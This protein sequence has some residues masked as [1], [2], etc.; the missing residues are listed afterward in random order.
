M[1]SSIE[2]LLHALVREISSGRHFVAVGWLPRWI[3]RRS[4]DAGT[5]EDEDPRWAD[6][7]SYRS[8]A[9]PGRG[10]RSCRS[11]RLFWICAKSP[12]EAPHGATVRDAH[13][14][15][16]RLGEYWVETRRDGERWLTRAYIDPMSATRLGINAIQ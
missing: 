9:S 8:A 11:G 15:R 1:V 5:R 7:G 14:G 3:G 13:R 16:I 6:P 10:I 4:F 12:F 2:A